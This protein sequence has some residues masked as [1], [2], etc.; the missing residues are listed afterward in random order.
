[1]DGAGRVSFLN[2]TTAHDRRDEGS[3][4]A[5]RRG[6]AGVGRTARRES[7]P[8]RA[9][10]REEERARERERERTTTTREREDDDAP[11]VCVRSKSRM[12]VLSQTPLNC[13]MRSRR[14]STTPARML[15]VTL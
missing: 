12:F 7:E 15:A 13:L 8:A 3:T 5:R 6:G 1:M 9:L 11:P 10:A 4:V 14:R 2:C